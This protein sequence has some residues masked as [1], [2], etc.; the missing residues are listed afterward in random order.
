[1]RKEFNLRDLHELSKRLNAEPALVEQDWRQV[2]YETFE[3]TEAQQKAVDDLE[4]NDS[5]RAHLQIQAAFREAAQAV[6]SGGRLRLR[7]SND[8]DLGRRT[9]RLEVSK[10]TDDT[11]IDP[12]PEIGVAII[13]CCADCKCW[14]ICGSDNPCPTCV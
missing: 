13:C 11:V 6:R 1:M 10:F 14:H 8:L 5:G 3:L 7:V 9:L 2:F 4:T 12:D